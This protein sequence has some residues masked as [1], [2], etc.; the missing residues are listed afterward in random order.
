MFVHAAKKCIFFSQNTKNALNI[1]K[2]KKMEK[3]FARV[4]V[5]KVI[6]FQSIFPLEPNFFFLQNHPFQAF[7]VSKTYIIILVKN[8]YKIESEA[9]ETG[10]LTPAQI[11][12]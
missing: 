10:T 1:M 7:L 12:L 8:L 5:Q 2:Q 6:F 11:Y 3:K 4:S 9:G